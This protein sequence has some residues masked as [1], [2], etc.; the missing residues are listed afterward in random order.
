MKKKNSAFSMRLV[1]LGIS[2]AFGS[3][4]AAT[5]EVTPS[6]APQAVAADQQLEFEV[7]MPLQNKADLETLLAQQRDPG[8]SNY[9]HWITPQEFKSRFGPDKE[10]LARVVQYLKTNKLTIVSQHT[11]G[12][13]VRGS[14]DAVQ[15][16]LGLKLE[17]RTQKG[18]KRLVAGRGQSIKAE[19]NNEGAMI[20]AFSSVPQHAVYSKTVGAIP[21]NRYGSWGAYWPTDIKQAYSFPAYPALSGAGTHVAI[22]MASD[23]LDSDTAAEFN[24][25]NWTG[26]TGLPV[27]TVTRVPILGGAA[28]STS[29]GASLEASL[30]VQQV[31]GMA[32]G[33]SVML[34]DTPDLQDSSIIAAYQ[35][36]ITDNVAD[37]VSSSFG[38]AEDYYTA[39]YNGGTDYTWIL[40]AYTQVFQQGN[41]QG[42]TFVAS[43]G[44][45]GGPAVVSIDYFNGVPNTAMLPGVSSPASDPNVTGVGGTNLQTITGQGLNSA[46]VGENADADPEVPNDPY[47]VGVNVTGAYWG[48]GGGVSKIFTQPSYQ[49]LVPTGSTMRTVPDVSLM[50]GGCPGSAV[51]PCSP[52]RSAVAISY[53]GGFT[54]VIGTSVSAPE[55]AGALALLVQRTG[56][57]LGNVNPMLYQKAVLQSHHIGLPVFHTGISGFNGYEYTAPVYNQVIGL[58]T[59]ILNQLIGAP[60]VAPAGLP[61]TPTNP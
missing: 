3:A 54:G 14:A 5:Y 25:E 35:Q 15:T 50:E 24:H 43:S 17:V 18:V 53:A 36:I 9:Q 29:N 10:S 56:H 30:D 11:Q 12:L 57:R 32:P 13:R 33:S 49:A 4:F 60:L 59:P 27:P 41:A 26:I 38:L 47:G 55:F 52:N 58:G 19:L 16:A 2:L 1:A 8:S 48:S 40:Q 44:D 22:V 45:S 23:V 21:A 51:Q 46:Y 34:Y 39:A 20:V 61:Q 28:F 7:I 31:T 6:N 42:I 37:V